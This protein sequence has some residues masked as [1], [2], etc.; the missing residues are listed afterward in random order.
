MEYLQVDDDI[1]LET[2]KLSLAP[3]IFSAIESNRTFLKKWLPF[4]D[5]TRKISDTED[6]INSVLDKPFKQRDNVYAIWYKG[7]FAGLI[8]Y[9][10]T[11]RMNCKTELGYWMIEKFQGKG[12]MTK[13]VSKLIDFAFRNLNMNRIQIKVATGNFKSAAI[14]KRLNFQ[15]EGIERHGEKHFN[16]FLNLEVYSFLKD[17]WVDSIKRKAYSV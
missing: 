5:Q 16:N 9:K 10:D 6:F 14:P 15:F 17:D 8:A 11:D 3:I 4:I 7:E 12:I 13:S 2:V 1:H